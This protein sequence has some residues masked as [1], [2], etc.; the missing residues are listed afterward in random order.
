MSKGNTV[1][2]SDLHFEH[3]IWKKELEFWEEQIITFIKRLE[4]VVVRWTDNEVRA[5]VEHFQNKFILHN[6][7][8][9]VLKKD[10]KRHEKQISEYAQEHPVAINHI[11][12]DDHTSLRDRMETQR[13]IYTELKN[14]YFKF[15]SK[16]M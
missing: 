2:I 4:E 8:I 9:D 3:V 16:T 10:V 5:Q 6:D 14:E 12:F 11:H 1:Y 13:E 7:V 15:L